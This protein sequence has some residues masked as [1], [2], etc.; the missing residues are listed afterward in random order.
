MYKAYADNKHGSIF[1]I[2]YGEYI[3]A[4]SQD[5]IIQVLQKMSLEKR[6]SITSVISDKRQC[7]EAT[8]QDTDYAKAKIFYKRI[9]ELFHLP[10][11]HLANY[12]KNVRHVHLLS[13]E[14]V[15]YAV[16]LERLQRTEAFIK[17]V[18]REVFTQESDALISIGLR[19]D[20]NY[21]KEAEFLFDNGSD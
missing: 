11:E 16:F 17:D 19:Q 3:G 9:A 7:R 2:H 20:Y 8:L 18:V 13:Q 15:D 6:R 5:S 1:I 12:L 21:L 10:E 14:Q 4:E